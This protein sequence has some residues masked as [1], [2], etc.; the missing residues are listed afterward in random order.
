MLILILALVSSLTAVAQLHVASVLNGKYRDNPNAQETILKGEVLQD[1]KLKYY[2]GLTLTDMP[3]A[4]VQI[5]PL[6]TRDGA[7]ALHREVS[8]K[9][10]TLYYAYYMLQRGCDV[11][12]YLFYLNRYPVG[13]N[14]IVLIYMEG[15]AGYDRIKKMLKR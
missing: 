13:G 10:G 8:Y 11:N 4:A 15:E 12:R 2:D 5:E 6:V 7:S 9:G 3:E 14:Q 1:Y